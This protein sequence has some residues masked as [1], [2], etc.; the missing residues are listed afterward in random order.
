MVEKIHD[1]LF[2]M[3]DSNINDGLHILSKTNDN[4]KT[5]RMILAILKYDGSLP[6]IRRCILDKCKKIGFLLVKNLLRNNRVDEDVIALQF[7]D[8]KFN[9]LKVNRLLILLTWIKDKL[10]PDLMKTDREIPQI[11]NA[12]DKRY[13]SPALA[14]H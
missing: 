5:A 10:Y 12:M 2:L 7:K 1:K 13:I 3:R 6:S 4:E 8:I 9:R 11:E 14:E